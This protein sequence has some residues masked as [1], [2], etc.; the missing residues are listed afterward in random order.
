VT[1]AEYIGTISVIKCDVTDSGSGSGSG[2]TITSSSGGGVS[3]DPT[4][5]N[6]PC[7]VP[8]A[9]A[10]QSI[11]GNLVIDVAQ[12]G[13]GGSSGTSTPCQTVTQSSLI[14][15]IT[16][17]VSN[18]CLKALLEALINGQT[19][20]TDVTNILRNTFGGTS[21]FNVTFIDGNFTSDPY[22]GQNA[23][24]T[25]PENGYNFDIKFNTPIISSSSQEYMMETAMHEIFHAYLYVN[26]TLL[27]GVTQHTYMIKNYVNTEVAALQQVFPNLSVHDAECLVLAG[28]GTLDA[29]TLNT[30]IAS[31]GLTTSDVAATN[32]NYKT[33]TAGTKCH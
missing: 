25:D 4:L 18:P 33:G 5:P 32:N 1:N 23:A 17:S 24:G 10:V 22:I 6:Q 13:S 14:N 20:Q 28:Y 26:H 30:A 3:G 16:D 11:S 27:N 7:T 19:L 29:S 21:D 8:A 2:G 31:Y 9:P 15:K 12:G